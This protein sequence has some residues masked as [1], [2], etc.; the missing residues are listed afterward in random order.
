VWIFIGGDW[1]F[2]PKKTFRE[3]LHF[4]DARPEFVITSR[5]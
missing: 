5:K 3:A 2:K 1:L 4:A